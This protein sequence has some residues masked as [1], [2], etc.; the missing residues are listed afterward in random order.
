LGADIDPADWKPDGGT[1]H[2]T[3]MERQV[4]GLL[5]GDNRD[6]EIAAALDLPLRSARE[7]IRHVRRKLAAKTIEEA[8]DRARGCGLLPG[9]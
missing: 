2:L 4:L 9:R 1:V 7:Q 8:V 3:P 5:T 6:V